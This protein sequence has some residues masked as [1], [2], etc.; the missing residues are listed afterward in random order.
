MVVCLLKIFYL[1]LINEDFCLVIVRVY[2]G[3]ME[4]IVEIKVHHLGEAI[5]VR[6]VMHHINVRI[7]I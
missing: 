1:E 6:Y 3:G 2:N 5:Q 7:I 4:H